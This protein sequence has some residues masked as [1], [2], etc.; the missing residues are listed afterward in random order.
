MLARYS[1]SIHYPF[2]DTTCPD[3]Q[4]VDW[5]RFAYVQYVTNAAYLCNAVMMFESLHRLKAKA[6]GLM[7]YPRQWESD[8]NLPR[9]TAQLLRKAKEEYN[10]DLNPI[11]LVNGGGDPTWAESF[12]KLLI[13][14]Q[15]QYSRVLL[16]DS[17]ATVLQPPDELFLMPSAP[18][19]M[20]RA[21]WLDRTMS[22]QLILVEPSDFEWARIEAGIANHTSKEFDM[23][24][25]NQLY[26]EDCI[27]IPHRRYDLLTGEFR[28]APDDHRKYLGSTEEVWDPDKV[29]NEARYIHF[30]DWPFPK[31]WI[32]GGDK[33]RLDRM[34][35]CRKKPG[36]EAEDCRDQQY[37]LRLYHD[38]SHRRLVYPDDFGKVDG[39]S[40]DYFGTASPPTIRQWRKFSEW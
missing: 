31:P 8:E 15:T 2:P 18:V 25:V 39:S 32:D 19:A 11:E 26:A 23:E 24:I 3:G 13:F 38:F 28:N 14:N 5:S 20:P 21:Y 33:A 35:E 6:G 40:Q 9:E 34:P 4:D 27:A 10:V 30:S 12:T 17:D 36:S 37:W 29:W 1:P 22:A 7:L 16:L